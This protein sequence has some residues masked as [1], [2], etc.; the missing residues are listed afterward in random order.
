[1]MLGAIFGGLGVVLVYLGAKGQ[2]HIQ[3]FGASLE[4]A[5]VG[6]ACIFLAAVMVILVIRRLLKSVEST[7][8]SSQSADDN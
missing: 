7:K 6:V 5:D 1:M 4:T 8:G 3:I 2:T